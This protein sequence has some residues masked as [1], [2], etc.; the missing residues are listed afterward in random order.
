MRWYK[1]NIE[2]SGT[3]HVWKFTF[4]SFNTNGENYNA[5]RKNPTLALSLQKTA[6]ELSFKIYA[7]H[8]FLPTDLY[9]GH[10]GSSMG[11]R[12][13]SKRQLEGYICFQ[14]GSF[15]RSGTTFSQAQQ[16]WFP[17]MSVVL[18]RIDDVSM[19]TNSL[20]GDIQTSILCDIEFIFRFHWNGL[21]LLARQR[22]ECSVFSAA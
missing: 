4:T 10:Y 8:L 12:I 7:R 3:S 11:K 18:D 21:C 15:R 6:R 5:K 19:H 22:M 13:C 14:A 9:S 17:V 16:T 2:N 20:P 1:T